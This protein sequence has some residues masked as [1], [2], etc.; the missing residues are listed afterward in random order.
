MTIEELLEEYKGCSGKLDI[1]RRYPD[2]TEEEDALTDSWACEHVSA[3]FALFAR[4]RGWGAVVIYAEE[5]SEPLIDYHAWVRLTRG[6]ESVDVDWTA[7]QYHNLHKPGHDEAVLALAWPL[8]W[9][10][11]DTHPVA[12]AFGY[13]REKS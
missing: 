4:R 9:P 6:T 3:D 13:I 1:W 11:G 8:V 10:S 7:R 2:I 12:G 5:A